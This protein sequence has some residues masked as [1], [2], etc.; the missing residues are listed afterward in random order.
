MDVARP[1]RAPILEAALDR[2][3][4]GLEGRDRL[5]ERDGLASMKLGQIE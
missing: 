4:S 1:P 5:V 3:G 2:I